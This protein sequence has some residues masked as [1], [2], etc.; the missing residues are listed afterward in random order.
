MGVGDIIYDLVK[1]LWKSRNDEKQQNEIAKKLAKNTFYRFYLEWETEI[2]SGRKIHWIKCQSLI[3][4]SY[5]SIFLDVATEIKEILPEQH[6][7]LIEIATKMKM[8]ADIAGTTTHNSNNLTPFGNE[9]SEKAKEYYN[10]LI[11]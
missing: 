8:G 11:N 5:H 4:Q 2:N 9:C 6:D 7:Q 1:E 3:L 10:K